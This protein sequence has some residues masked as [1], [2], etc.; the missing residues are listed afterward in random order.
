[1]II[2]ALIITYT[3]TPKS[4]TN[5]GLKTPYG[6]VVLQVADGDE[7]GTQ[8]LGVKL[9]HPAT[10]G[11]KNRDLV[12]QVGGIDTR[13]LEKCCGILRSEN[14]NKSGRNF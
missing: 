1:L 14:E 13:P 8:S 7:K 3:N 9:C 11:H 5:E 6:G 10:R 2:I 12:L 4:G